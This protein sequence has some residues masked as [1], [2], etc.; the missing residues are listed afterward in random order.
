MKKSLALIVLLFVVSTASAQFDNYFFPK[1]MRYDYYHAG[2]SEKEYFF[3]DKVLEEPYWAGSRTQLTDALG[4]GN[5]QFR[6][7]DTATGRLIYSRGF[8][9]LFQE[10]QASP[11]AKVTQIAHPES[12][13]FPYP[14]NKF[15][16]EFYSRNKANEF[17]KRFEQVIDPNHYSVEKRRYG[18]DTFEVLY[19][20]DPAKKVDIVLLSEGYAADQKEQFEQ[21]CQEFADAIFSFSP[22]KEMK[23]A[24][25]IRAV[26]LPSPEPGVTIP[27]E[28]IWK[29]T[30]LG[31]K[32]YTF[33]SERYQMTDDLQKVRDAA[34]SVPYDLIYILSN[35]QKYG[36]GGV[37]NYYGIS[38]ANNKASSAKIY[39]HEFGHLLLGLGDEYDYGGDDMALYSSKVEPWEPNITSLADFSK[40]KIWQKHLK[41][42]TPVPTA[43]VAP[44]TAEVGVF[45]GAGYFTKGLYRPVMSCLMRDFSSDTF[46]P[47]CSDAI[48]EMINTYLK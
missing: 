35:T 12:V 39:V 6:I 8:C 18:Y 36:G 42:T 1:S 23:T 14:K 37:Y 16:I 2:N 28:H 40:K 38:A 48:V 46:C 27:G 21:D 22:Y 25:N 13:V 4:Y 44:Y 30:P 3:F 31:A 7:Y 43:K 34:G 19:N 10:W 20:G 11:E 32:F 45:E 17:E 47:V 41:I 5:H 9:S 29:N 26:W 15:R 33:G 24:F